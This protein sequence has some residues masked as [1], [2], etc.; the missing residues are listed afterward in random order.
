MRNKEFYTKMAE[1]HIR[2]SKGHKA[3]G[4]TDLADTHADAAECCLQMCKASSEDG[5]D[6]IAPT[7]AHAVL[8]TDNPTARLIA[9]PG[10]VLILPSDVGEDI[11]SKLDKSMGRV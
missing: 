8:P 10:Q 5:L 3:L 6:K 11:T 1:H 7:N 2:M 9:R 4:Q